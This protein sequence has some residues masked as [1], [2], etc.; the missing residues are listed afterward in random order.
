MPEIKLNVSDADLSR[1]NA[2]AAAAGIPRA[3]LVRNRA[4]A[5]LTTAEY[6]KIVAATC[7]K[8]RGD[9]PRTTIEA[10][11]AHVLCQHLSQTD[12]SR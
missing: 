11:V 5:R 6:H 3:H 12:A 4:I 2:Q 1:L 8:W 9:I 7:H 10:I